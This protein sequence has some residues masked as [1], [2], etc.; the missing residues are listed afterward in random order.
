MKTI[1]VLMAL[2]FSVG[3]HVEPRVA[4][5]NPS[6]SSGWKLDKGDVPKYPQDAVRQHLEGDVLLNVR[7]SP[8]GRIDNVES[9]RGEAVLVNA[10]KQSVASWQFKPVSGATPSTAHVPVGIQF[11]L[12]LGLA[13]LLERSQGLTITRRVPGTDSIRATAEVATAE[14]RTKIA[15]AL[16]A[17]GFLGKVSKG[18]KDPRDAD[19]GLSWRTQG[20][21][22]EMRFAE[23]PHKIVVTDEGR[24]WAGDNGKKSRALADELRAV[25]P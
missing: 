20:R 18:A 1:V 19:W 17:G 23:E 11:R 3:G 13:E 21:V 16:T 6:P 15:R 7:I 25:L 8:A 12:D 22:I 24:K 14:G 4:G 2:S 9:V 10:V 5:W